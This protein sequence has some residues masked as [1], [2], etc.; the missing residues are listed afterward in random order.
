MWIVSRKSN[1]LEWFWDNRFFPYFVKE[2][3]YDS[4]DLD[5]EI[6]KLVCLLAEKPDHRTKIKIQSKL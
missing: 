5:I 6:L 4:Q 1:I 3:K 2:K